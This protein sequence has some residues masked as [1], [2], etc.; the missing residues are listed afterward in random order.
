VS[1]EVKAQSGMGH[2]LSGESCSAIEHKKLREENERLKAAKDDAERSRD[3][4]IG[5]CV[6]AQEQ[7]RVPETSEEIL[8]ALRSGNNEP[9]AEPS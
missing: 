8:A 2:A 5:R 9:A 3:D 4:A 6:A 1:E 7:V